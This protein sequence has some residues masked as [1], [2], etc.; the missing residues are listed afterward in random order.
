VA[1]LAKD[2]RPARD[3]D[4]TAF[5]RALALGAALILIATATAVV[6][7]AA[8][9][10]DLGLNV[11]AHLATIG[12]ACALTPAML[13]RRRGDRLHRQLGYLWVAAMFSTAL[14]S[15]DIRLIMD[16][17]F[18]PIHILSLLVVLTTPLVIITARRH[19]VR[20]HRRLVRLLTLGALLIAGFFTFPFNRL[21]GSWLIYG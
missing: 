17:G 2:E 5:D 19:E 9:W 18:S 10:S 1:T 4:V 16:G 13:L 12:I 15:F 21:L 11:W 14:I 20:R 8:Y 6:R 7:G 3:T